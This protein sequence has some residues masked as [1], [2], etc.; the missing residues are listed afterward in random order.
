MMTRTRF[1]AAAALA[2]AL[3]HAP[4]AAQS[5]R[6]DTALAAGCRRAVA[7][8]SEARVDAI[9]RG[10]LTDLAP[11]RESGPDALARI[12]QSIPADEPALRELRFAS[13]RVRDERTLAALLAIAGNPARER[14][15]RLSAF[16]VL[17]VYVD[18]RL[19][20]DPENLGHAPIVL[21]S[22]SHAS[23]D[24]GSEPPRP[25]A[26][27]RIIALLRQVG[28]SDADPMAPAAR[29]LWEALVRTRPELGVDDA[30]RLTLT[31]V[32]EFTFRITNPNPI[33]LLVEFEGD[34]YHGLSPIG[35]R[36]GDMELRAAFRQSARLMYQGREIATVTA[37]R[38]RC[39]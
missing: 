2:A 9:V 4:A 6:T 21:G 7:A 10:E 18:P 30:E 1:C 26:A 23:Y 32:C 8:L 5:E 13:R 25:D 19:V 15:V 33:S 20:F 34:H 24:V 38:E 28:T 16:Q 37:S 17:V 36:P 27:E 31:A 11:C 39:R 29:W 14:E 22:G 12:W 35:V 3:I